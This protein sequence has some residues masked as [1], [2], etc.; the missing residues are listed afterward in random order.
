MNP[1]NPYVFFDG[2]CAEAMQFYE[3]VFK[4]KLDMMLY[5][6]EAPNGK[7]PM[8]GRKAG[9]MHARLPIYGGSLMASDWLAD[10]PFER[11]QGF[12]VSLVCPDM[13][14][15]KRIFKALAEGGEVNMPFEKTFFAEGFGMVIDKYGTPWMVNGPEKPMQDLLRA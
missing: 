10:R 9:V 4:V 12:Y 5:E 2:D 7:P 14:E 8:A 6:S 1:L 15:A 13:K 3:R 11:K